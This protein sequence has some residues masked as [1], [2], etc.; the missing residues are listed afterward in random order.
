[1]DQVEHGFR[2]K[3][4]AASTAMAAALLSGC[5]STGAPRADVSALEAE[6]AMAQGRHDRAVQHAEAAVAGDPRN[7]SY[8]AML[9]KSYLDAGR[10]ASAETSF[11][12]AMVLGDNSPRTALS[13]ALS[14]TAQA[15]YGEAAALLNDWEGEIATADLGLALALA[16]QPERGIH[17]MS[18][19]IRGG[20]NTVKMRQNLAYAY[21]V[22]GRWREARA[23]AAQDVPADQLSNRIAQWAEL[24]SPLAYEQ[25]IAGLLGVPSGVQDRGQPMQ[26]ALANTP[27]IEQ[28]ASEAS[29]LAQADA[30]A[31]D[32][33]QLAL[34]AERM[35]VPATGGELPAVG[36]PAAA[37]TRYEAPAAD[38]SG[39]FEQAFA[40]NAQASDGTIR[41]VNDPLVQTVPAR[42]AAASE[43]RVSGQFATPASRT[44]ARSTTQGAAERIGDPR[45]VRADT[46]EPHLVQLG[47]FSSEQGARRAW[48]IY[49]SRYPELADREMVITEAVVRGKR[50]F[51]VSAGGY[52]SAESRAMCAR[53]DAANG[54]GCISWAA[55]SPLP[56]AIDNGTRFARR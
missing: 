6:E 18:N 9:G 3:G 45:P 16:G 32:S 20:Q 43:R 4:L 53:V 47:S 24:A 19:A 26:L 50:Y 52:D 22:A 55:S 2:M 33:Q 23:M 13:L 10:F 27:S 1:M 36:R 29:A 37:S 11:N 41:Y 44:V 49:V 17:L 12:D 42:Q 34:S 7:A 46:D 14:M 39:D 5:A 54:D 28:L 56:G 40:S 31:A 8:R 51:R 25:R 35:S 21:A 30:P 15:K 48:G 38:R